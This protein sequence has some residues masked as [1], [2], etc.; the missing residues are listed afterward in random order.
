[1]SPE[2]TLVE[3]TSIELEMLGDLTELLIDTVTDGASIGFLAPLSPEAAAAYWRDM[4]GP[5][6]AA[7]VAVKEGR[8]VGSVQLHLAM[9]PNASHR[10]EIA[11]LMV[12]TSYR[13]SGIARLLMQAAENRAQAEGRSLIILDTRAGDPS[14]QLYLSLGY[15]EAGRI[16]RFAQSSSGTLDD[17]VLYYKEFM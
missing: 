1:M 10:A 9:K 14:N 12:H 11:K 8:I 13:R 16:P 4:P 17:T 7:W 15:R 3:L 6:V 2:V 5:G